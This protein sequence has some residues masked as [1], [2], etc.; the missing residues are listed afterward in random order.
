MLAEN[1]YAVVQERCGQH[2]GVR[3][4]QLYRVPAKTQLYT[5]LEPMERTQ[6][7]A[8]LYEDETG[9]H[10][11]GE[12]QLCLALLGDPMATI[13]QVGKAQEAGGKM[14]ESIGK[15]QICP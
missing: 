3:R 8:F 7:C 15:S 12:R 10:V 5:L 14:G 13:D 9:E 4:M 1:L 6:A 11:I 2:S